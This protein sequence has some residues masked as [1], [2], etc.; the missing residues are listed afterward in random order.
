MLA[1][2]FEAVS[3]NLIRSKSLAQIGDIIYQITKKRIKR[4]IFDNWSKQ[5][6]DQA[7]LFQQN[8]K[9]DSLVR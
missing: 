8:S 5:A 4:S 3:Q 2:C 1:N 9:I 6:Q 7:E